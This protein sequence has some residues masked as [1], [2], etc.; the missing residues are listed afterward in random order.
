MEIFAL[1]EHQSPLEMDVAQI[2]SNVAQ[3]E[4]YQVSVLTVSET[5]KF[6][7]ASLGCKAFKLIQDRG[8]RKLITYY[9]S[10]TD[11]D[12]VIDNDSEISQKNTNT[13]KLDKKHKETK[14][15]KKI[16]KSLDD[17]DKLTVLADIRSMLRKLGVS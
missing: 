12:K 17:I 11:L 8:T 13:T 10:W 14:R 9:E 16:D 5:T 15:A 2:E 6:R 7:V 1:A 4:F 3:I